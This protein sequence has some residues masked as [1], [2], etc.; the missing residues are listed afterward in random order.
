MQGIR[1]GRECPMG[2]LSPFCLSMLKARAPSTLCPHFTSNALQFWSNFFHSNTQPGACLHL[3]GVILPDHGSALEHPLF[4][5]FPQASF[6]KTHPLFFQSTLF[7]LIAS[8]QPSA[9]EGSVALPY[10]Q[11][12]PLVLF[13]FPAEGS[14]SPAEACGKRLPSCVQSPLQREAKGALTSRSKYFP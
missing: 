1:A 11:N 12:F 14:L 5:F 4:F 9:A 7:P 10:A 6:S 2:M 3:L 8:A 13:V